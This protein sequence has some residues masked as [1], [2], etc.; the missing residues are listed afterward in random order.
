M[1]LPIAALIALA[2]LAVPVSWIAQACHKEI[3]HP[4][5]SLVPIQWGSWPIR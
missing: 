4:S 3:G 2:V 1:K 5:V